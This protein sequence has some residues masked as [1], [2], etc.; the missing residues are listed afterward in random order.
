MKV[1]TDYTEKTWLENDVE[2]AHLPVESPPLCPP[3]SRSRH[4]CSSTHAY[5]RMPDCSCGLTGIFGEAAKR[6]V[7]GG[8]GELGAECV[9]R[10]CGAA[11][12]LGLSPGFGEVTYD[13]CDWPWPYW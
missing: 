4:C 10:T 6:G 3:F 12:E 8:T 2:Y 5:M 13:V 1:V 9:K 7:E 11:S